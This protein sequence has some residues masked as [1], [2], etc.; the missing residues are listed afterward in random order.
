MATIRAA[1]ATIG[2]ATACIRAAVLA[3]A[4]AA[5]PCGKAP[6]TAAAIAAATPAP[7]SAAATA[8]AADNPSSICVA[9]VKLTRQP[10]LARALAHAAAAATT[11][12]AVRA[13][14]ARHVHAASSSLE[15][16][17]PACGSGHVAA[18]C[19]P[20]CHDFNAYSSTHAVCRNRSLAPRRPAT[21]RLHCG[22]PQQRACTV[23]CRN[24]R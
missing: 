13:A 23:G 15:A 21:A 16:A 4:S 17:P 9:R 5:N 10:Q 3:S 22:L 18:D 1:A 6:A 2:A 8:T 11:C 14:H 20:A 24:A 19:T 12:S 7:S